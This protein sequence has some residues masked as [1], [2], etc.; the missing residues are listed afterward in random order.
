[1][2]KTH[3]EK[4]SAFGLSMIF[5]KTKELSHPFQ[6]ID[7]K[8]RGYSQCRRGEVQAKSPASVNGI[9]WP[10]GREQELCR[11]HGAKRGQLRSL[12]FSGEALIA[13]AQPWERPGTATLTIFR[14]LRSVAV[15]SIFLVG[16]KRMVEFPDNARWF[17]TLRSI[18][19]LISLAGLKEMECSCPNLS[20]A[21]TCCL[22]SAQAGFDI[23]A[24]FSKSES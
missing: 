21:A 9:Q 6:D 19:H 3:I 15:E 4:M 17:A 11:R 2:L 23:P 18:L 7:E 13:L 12:G 14:L 1:L 24:N 22:L 10:R 16:G 20:G 8:K 5:M